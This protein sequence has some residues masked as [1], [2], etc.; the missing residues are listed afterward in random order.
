MPAE[1]HNLTDRGV[2]S[3][4]Q[5]PGIAKIRSSDRIRRDSLAATEARLKGDQ[6]LGATIAVMRFPSIEGFFSTLATSSSA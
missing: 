1:S 2:A 6:T 5:I 4:R 3:Q